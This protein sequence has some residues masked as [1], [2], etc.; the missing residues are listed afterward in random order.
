MS[1][2]KRFCLDCGAEIDTKANFCPKC[3]RARVKEAEK[4]EASGVLE[5]A[6][7]PYTAA[8]EFARACA[9]EPDCRL[10]YKRGCTY[11]KMGE[12]EKAADDFKVF[13]LA[14]DRHAELDTNPWG[15]LKGATK[16]ARIGL[17]RTK[18]Q[19]CV[20]QQTF[21]KILS[22]YDFGVGYSNKKL[23][24]WKHAIIGDTPEESRKMQKEK[25]QEAA[26]RMG[27]KH[28]LQGKCKK[29]IQYL[30]E[31]IEMNPEDARSYLYRGIAR[32][33]QSHK[34]GYFGPSSSAR[35]LSKTKALSDIE[36]AKALSKGD[37]LIEQA[38]MRA[39]KQIINEP[40]E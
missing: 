15:F 20:T 24:D 34:G 35:E 7:E 4:C 33:L 40:V 8:I 21:K 9:F 23:Y 38:C 11:Q 2:Q 13:L 22:T 26:Y 31:A 27:V 14:D 29:A 37:A 6:I 5:G 19:R 18:A 1:K 10:Y 32:A 16:G 17:Q 36:R 30:D 39:H 12:I 25:P 28:L 3:A